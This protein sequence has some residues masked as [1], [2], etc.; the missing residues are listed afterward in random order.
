MS[1]PTPEQHRAAWSLAP[2]VPRSTLEK[3]KVR[4]IAVTV[5]LAKRLWARDQTPLRDR[6]CSLT[7]RTF[8]QERRLRDGHAAQLVE[9]YADTAA[10]VDDSAFTR[11]REHAL[12]ALACARRGVETLPLEAFLRVVTST[13]AVR[14]RL[15][16]ALTPRREETMAEQRTPTAD[17]VGQ[18]S[19]QGTPSQGLGP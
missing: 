16:S 7:R 12:N 13:P 10:L 9:A 19:P 11:A 6:I 2:Y 3:A 8:V 4:E 5:S 17:A 18:I 1:A 15:G 14:M